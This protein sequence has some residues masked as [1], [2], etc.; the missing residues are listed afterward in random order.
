MT[1]E[2]IREIY[3]ILR[4]GNTAEIKKEQGNIVVVEIYRKKK[5]KAPAK[6]QE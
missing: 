3:R 4:K 1:E 5:I 6:G 2:M